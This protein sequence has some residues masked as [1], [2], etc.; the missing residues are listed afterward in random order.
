MVA[1]LQMT[2]SDAFFK[3]QF[4]ILI[5]IPPKFVHKGPI[6]NKGESFQVMPSCR[7][8]TKSPSKPMQTKFTDAYMRH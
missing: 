5:R 6:D 1:N 4:S 7:I 2:F 3:E 8:G